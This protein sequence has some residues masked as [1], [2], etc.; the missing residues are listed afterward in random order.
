LEPL[1]AIAY[2]DFGILFGCALGDAL[3]GQLDALVTWGVSFGGIMT[4]VMLNKSAPYLYYSAVEP[5]NKAPSPPQ[6]RI[7]DQMELGKWYETDDK[8]RLDSCYAL[9]SKGLLVFAK[10]GRFD[11]TTGKPIE[12]SPEEMLLAFLLDKQPK[13]APLL[14]RKTAQQGG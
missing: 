1:S 12:A 10:I 13:A 6:Q 4:E 5:T 3:R 14:F 8:D 2:S 7:L 9:V 11:K